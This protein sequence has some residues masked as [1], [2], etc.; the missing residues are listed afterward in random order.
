MMSCGKHKQEELALVNG[1]EIGLN[2]FLP[3]YRNFLSKTHQND[4]LS[5]RYA[6]LNSMIDESI[7][8]EYAKRSGFNNSPEI[9]HKKA[10][11]HDQLLLNEYYDKKVIN[12][13]QITD[14]E[15]RQLFKY[16]NTRLHVRHLYAP[17]LE[18]I[19]DISNKIDS[20]ISWEYLAETCFED[21]ILK[22]NGGDIG[23]YK[24]GELDP[25]FE[26]TAY[27]LL[28]GEISEPTKTRD[29]FSL[30]QVLEREKDV[31]LTEQ[32]YQLNKDWLKQMAVRYKRLPFLRKFTDDILKDLAIQF[33]ENGLNYLLEGLSNS[34]ENLVLHSDAKVLKLKN[35]KQLSVDDCMKNISKLSDRQFKRIRSTETLKSILSGIFVRNEILANA[36]DLHLDRSKYFIDTFKQ[37]YTSL[38]LRETVGKTDRSTGVNWQEEYF[39]FRDKIAL[40]NDIMIDS[41]NVRSFPMVFKATI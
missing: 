21:S 36:K 26:I 6:F 35:K 29:G 30:I 1:H 32:D 34:K 4:N 2:D 19:Q 9:L 20:G 25:A 17:D 22:N 18:T 16:Y 23:W 24:M 7:I 14:N 8:L 40:N 39:Q 5:N 27:E 31:F 38:I 13:I 33:D 28:D 37:E 12:G 41:V 10:Q 15:L 3:K 11:I